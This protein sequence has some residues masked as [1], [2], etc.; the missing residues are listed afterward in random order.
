LI[1]WVYNKVR[2]SQ[3]NFDVNTTLVII[4]MNEPS[5]KFSW[6]VF[7]RRAIT[8]NLEYNIQLEEIEAEESL[9]RND[10]VPSPRNGI[11]FSKKI[12]FKVD[13][14]PSWKPFISL[15]SYCLEDYDE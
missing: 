10:F 3:F 14:L 4:K 15:D 9:F 8:Q 11:L 2:S 6:G 12:E 1:V 7:C 5:V 13:E